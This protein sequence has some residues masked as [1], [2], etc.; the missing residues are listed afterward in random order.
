V[1][2]TEYDG[3]GEEVL[4]RITCSVCDKCMLAKAPKEEEPLSKKVLP[5]D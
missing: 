5:P 4:C 3:W 1:I 2:L